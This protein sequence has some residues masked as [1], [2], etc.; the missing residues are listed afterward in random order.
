MV[1]GMTYDQFWYGDPW[2]ARAYKEAFMIRQRL[3][4]QEMWI[5]GAYICDAVGVALNNGFNK[6]KIEYLRTPLDFY[7]KTEAE[8]REEVREKKLKL[9]QQLSKISANFKNKQKGTDKDGNKS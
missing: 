4:N 8:K 3:R 7:P 6:K 5:Q 2:M 9:I 1:Y